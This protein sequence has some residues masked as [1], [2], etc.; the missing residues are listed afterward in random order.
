[1]PV[2]ELTMEQE[3]R[4]SQIE[5][6]LKEASKEDLITIFIALQ[7]QNMVLSNNIKQLL[8]LWPSHP[9]TTPEET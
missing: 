9:P 5:R 6:Q 1:M 2:I 8:Q 3:F 4:M 7:H